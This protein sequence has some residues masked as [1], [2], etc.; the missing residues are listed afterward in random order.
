MVGQSICIS[1]PGSSS[2]DVTTTN[3]TSTMTFT[4]FTGDW[5]TGP[6]PTQVTESPTYTALP[7]KFTSLTSTYTVNQTAQ[8]MIADYSKYCPIL[9]DDYEDGFQWEDLSGNCQDLLD[10]YCSPD[11]HSP[12]PKSTKFP[13][14]CTPTA[15]SATPTG[16][17]T[18]IPSP[19]LDGTTSKCSN[20]YYIVA[21]D[22]CPAIVKEYGI[23]LTDFYSWNPGVGSDCRTLKTEY[24][25]CVAVSGGSNSMNTTGTGSQ[26]ATGSRTATGSSTSTTTASANPS[27]T[28]DGVASNCDKWHYVED[29]D[30]CFDLAKKYNITLIEFYDWNPAIGEGRKSL[31][32][33]YFVCV[34]V[35]GGTAPSSTTTQKPTSTSD[36]TTTS[37]SETL[38][39]TIDTCKKY[40]KVLDGDGCYAVAAAH[41]ITLKNAFGEGSGLP[42][43]SVVV[44][45]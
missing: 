24:Y 4:M 27:P 6:A 31:I 1:P 22:T 21:N 19:T 2:W 17:S 35:K 36:G 10:P 14:S 34:G 16:S 18:P 25:V 7:T 8:S 20:F 41:D 44:Q 39:G 37:P 38:P 12:S 11:I 15:V 13:G 9:D 32:T 45:P 23:K 30:G 5:E 3:R 26:T 42:S 40:N 29:G 43:S 33:E 28:E